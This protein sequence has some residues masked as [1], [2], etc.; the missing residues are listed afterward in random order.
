MKGR[1]GVGALVLT[2]LPSLA[3]AQFVPCSGVTTSQD[4]KL[5]LDD[6][7]IG[8]ANDPDLK[9]FMEALRASLSIN[10]ATLQADGLGTVQ[11]VRCQN[12]KPQETDF[13]TTTVRQLNSRR[14]ILEMWGVGRTDGTAGDYRAFVT[15][16][17]IPVRYAGTQSPATF[18]IERHGKSGSPLDRLMEDVSQAAE[19]KAYVAVGMGTKF[20]QE[21]QYDLARKSLCR[22]ES[23]LADAGS[24]AAP[25]AFVTWVK[26]VSESVVRKALDDPQYTGAL[27]LVASQGAAPCLK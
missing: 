18:T 2:L 7:A 19:L 5:L 11:L 15:Y 9:L 20:M 22:A 17:V 10:L 1:S 21:G 6:F 26:S 3:A 24:A 27:R 8:N 23:W 14:V 4:Y 13:D 12:R 16:F 25:P